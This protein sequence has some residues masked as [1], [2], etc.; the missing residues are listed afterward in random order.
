MPHLLAGLEG[1]TGKKAPNLFVCA[2]RCLT[3]LKP[4]F[5]LRFCVDA[6]AST[7]LTWVRLKA[8]PLQF[9]RRPEDKP[10]AVLGRGEGSFGPDA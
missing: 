4:R 9:L 3:G 5:S 2:S 8:H 10:L 7:Y 1:V 6:E